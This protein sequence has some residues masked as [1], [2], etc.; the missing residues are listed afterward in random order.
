MPDWTIIRLLS[1]TQSYFEE[2]GVD[3]PRLSAEIL[4]AHSLGIKRLDLYLQHDRPLEAK[5]LSD[6]K[7][8]IQRR[9][10]QEPVAYITGERGFYESDFN[11]NPNVLIPR[12]DTELLVEKAVEYLQPQKDFKVLELGAGSGAVIISIAKACPGHAFFA[13]DVTLDAL[14]TAAANAAAIV[15]GTIRFFASSWLLAIKSKPVFD[16]IVSN[17]PYIRSR[18][19]AGLMTEVKDYEPVQALDGG[20][21]GMEC[22]RAILLQAQTCLKKGGM[23]MFEI[24][25]DQKNDMAQVVERFKTFEITAFEKDLA[26]HDRMVCIQKIN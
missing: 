18:D 25:F 13:S 17:P 11:V 7:L 20:P 8:L 26:G 9:S 12:P 6:Y 3:S 1:W 15:P 24:G 22:Y 2:H 23:L 5:E 14:R 10:R 4:L 19:I 21:D 16:L